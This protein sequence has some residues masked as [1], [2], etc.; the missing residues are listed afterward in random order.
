MVGSNA[1]AVGSNIYNVGGFI[2]NVH[3]S[4]RVLILDCKSHTWSEAPN[5]Q[6]E[7]TAPSACL[8]DEKKLCSKRLQRELERGI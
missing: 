1:V 7:R 2:D 4:S 8:V 3:S 6:V 5:M